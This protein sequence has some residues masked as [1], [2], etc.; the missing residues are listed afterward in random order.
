MRIRGIYTADR[1]QDFPRGALVGTLTA[2]ASLLRHGRRVA[3]H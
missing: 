2:E 3:W 1:W